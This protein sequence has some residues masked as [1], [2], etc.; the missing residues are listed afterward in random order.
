MRSLS[1]YLMLVQMSTYSSMD[2][3]LYCRTHFEQL[4]K[5]SGNFSKNFQNGNMKSIFWPI[6]SFL[7]FPSLIQPHKAQ[8]DKQMSLSVNLANNLCC[9]IVCKYGSK[10]FWEARRAGMFTILHYV[11]S[12]YHYLNYYYVLFLIWNLYW[13]LTEQDP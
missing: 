13:S 10:V 7:F 11:C 3:V 5:E 8:I 6:S 4:F 9:L 12:Y 1:Y 2:G